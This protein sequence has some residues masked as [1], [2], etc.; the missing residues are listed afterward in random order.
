MTESR[1]STATESNNLQPMTPGRQFL[2]VKLT[3]L[4]L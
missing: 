3:R 1:K 2:P 4:F